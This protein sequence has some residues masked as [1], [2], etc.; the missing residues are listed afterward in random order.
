M[1]GKKQDLFHFFLGILLFGS[2]WGFSEVVLGS[3]LRI[4]NFPFRAGLLVG[5]GMATIGAALAL[6]KRPFMFVGM[7]VITALCKLLSV[8]LLHI[9]LLC[10]ANSSIA[11]L[12]EAAAASV[13]ISI[14]MKKTDKSLGARIG[15]GALAGIIGSAGFYFIGMRVA[16]CPYLLSFKTNLVGFMI[17]EGL[18]WTVFSAVL[19]PVGYYVGVRIRSSNLLAKKPAFIYTGSVAISLICWGLSVLSIIVLGY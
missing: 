18:S 7:G 13:I 9:S 11:V 14:L 2:I 3:G 15:A 17:R 6:Y 1:E 10:K 12:L 16:P 19:L 8:P 5:I 4:M